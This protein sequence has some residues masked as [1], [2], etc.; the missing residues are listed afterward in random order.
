MVLY[1]EECIPQGQDPSNSMGYQRFT[2]KEVPLR[3]TVLELRGSFLRNSKGTGKNPET[4][5]GKI[6]IPCPQHQGLCTA[7]KMH[8]VTT[9]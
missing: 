9:G 7:D 8:P 1:T 2:K 4:L 3:P 6:T 5:N